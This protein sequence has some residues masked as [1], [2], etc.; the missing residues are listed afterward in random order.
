MNFKQIEG[1]VE[2][3]QTLNF[4]KAASNL[5]ITQPALSYLISSAEEEIGFKIFE[6]SG[7][8]VTLTA[9]GNQFIPHLKNIQS[10]MKFAIEQG[11]NI[12]NQYKKILNLSIPYRSC[13]VL[14]KQILT[15]FKQ[16][17]PDIFVEIKYE[18]NQKALSSTQ[19]D[20]I[21][22]YM[23]SLMKSPLVKTHLIYN[24][25]IYLVCNHTDP[26]SKKEI[27]T[28][29]DLDY[30]TLLVGST[31]P[32]ELVEAQ[33][34]VLTNPTVNQI[35][36]YGHESTLTHIAMNDAI[37]L[38]PGFLNDLNNEFKWIPFDCDITMPICFATQKNESR[39]Y[40]LRFI[41]I[42]KEVYNINKN[43]HY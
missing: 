7:K 34:M 25:G 14:I 11:Q 19:W 28:P 1:I 36:S 24:S 23:P 41:E 12:G 8:S 29:S 26:L 18:P 33:K 21:C 15:Q 37:C 22:G 40:V 16:E 20:L 42:T 4:S 38:I 30:Q 2:V 27:I 17:Y 10:I 5:F 9:A 3:S 43:I 13:L 31:S 35:N 6:R 39:D 32:K